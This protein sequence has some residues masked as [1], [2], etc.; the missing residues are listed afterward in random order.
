MAET[1]AGRTVIVT[2]ASS[3]IGLAIVQRLLASGANVV[4]ADRKGH[5]PAQGDTLLAVPCDVTDEAAVAA[6]MERATERFG[7][8]DGVCANAGITGPQHRLHEYPAADWDGVMAVDLRG[9][10]L[11]VKHALAALRTSGGG[12]IV[13]T[14]SVGGFHVTPGFAAYTA[15]K[16]GAIMLARQA[17]VEYAAEGIRV[18]AICPGPMDT[19]IMA[20][21]PADTRR[22]LAAGIPLGRLG[23]PGEAAA[24]AVFLLSDA[25]AYVTGQHYTVDG[26]FT[27]R[28]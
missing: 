2:G 7:R 20:G 3:G 17:A 19:P 1:L 16:A 15:A 8:I 10:F 6:L 22:E 24:L 18:N 25:A 23:D 9:A 11:T 26:G 5:C 4:A 14:A 27:I 12:A 13:I 21:L 28:P